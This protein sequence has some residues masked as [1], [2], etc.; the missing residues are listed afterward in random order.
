MQPAAVSLRC[1]ETRT[2][3]DKNWD[4][5]QTLT[6]THAEHTL[7][8]ST[9]VGVTGPEETTSLARRVQRRMCGCTVEA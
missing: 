1:R 5:P 3:V 8:L 9:E 6:I 7:D 4:E 2:P